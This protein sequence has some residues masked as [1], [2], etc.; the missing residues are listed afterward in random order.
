MGTVQTRDEASLLRAA[1]AGNRCAVIE[2][3]HD[4]RVD[5]TA[6]DHY[7]L[8]RA[9]ELGWFGVVCTYLTSYRGPLP[10]DVL[11]TVQVAV[12]RAG[13]ADL[14]A[15][16]LARPD[17]DFAPVGHE[18]LLAAAER[19]DGGVLAALLEWTGPAGERLPAAANGHEVIR[20]L[21]EAG[22]VP[23]IEVMLAYP[24][25]RA[26]VPHHPAPVDVGPSQ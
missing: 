16:L 1:V 14:V 23:M 6:A 18:L 17:I 12:V 21:A 24:H 5:A 19:G 25:V 3:L 15:Y 7:V 9:C 13:P 22:D 26:Q 2:H 11:H 20:R 4:E 10:P 8:V